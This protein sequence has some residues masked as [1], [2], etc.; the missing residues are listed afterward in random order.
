MNGTEKQIAWAN[1]IIETIDQQI[2]QALS[3]AINEKSRERVVAGQTIW[4]A[5]KS[6]ASAH[7]IIERFRDVNYSKF[8]P[9]AMNSLRGSACLIAQYNSFHNEGADLAPLKTLLEAK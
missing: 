6:V 2:E 9:L 3:S 4:N 5:I 1:E 7:G 8:G